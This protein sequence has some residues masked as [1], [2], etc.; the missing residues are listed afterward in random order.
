[1]TSD[2]DPLVV[3]I[4]IVSAFWSVVS[5]LSGAI[6]MGL[7][8]AMVAAV[9]VVALGASVSDPSEAIDV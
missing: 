8:S 4:M 6:V 3:S 9:A 1:M 7:L 5:F 2:G